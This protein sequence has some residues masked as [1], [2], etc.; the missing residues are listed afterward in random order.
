LE[1]LDEY[2][3][4]DMKLVLN[5]YTELREPAGNALVDLSLR[6][7]IEMRDLVADPAFQLR[8]KI[9]RNVQK[10]HPDQWTPLYSLV[11]FTNIPYHE[12]MA[13]GERHDEIMADILALEN[14]EARWDSKEVEEMILQRL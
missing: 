1:L 5:R 13:Q 4:S 6:N 2:G 12:A 8:K 11:K 9:E 10:N 14:I 3:D 7:F